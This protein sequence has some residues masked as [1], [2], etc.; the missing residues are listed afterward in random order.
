MYCNTL[1]VSHSA[2]CHAGSSIY[3]ELCIYKRR[4]FLSPKIK[5]A[6]LH[7]DEETVVNQRATETLW[8]LHIG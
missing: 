7:S 8:E 4:L 6:F 3:N 1:I 5:A 2:D